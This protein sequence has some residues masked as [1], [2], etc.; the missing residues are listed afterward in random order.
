MLTGLLLVGVTM[1]A[2]EEWE[3]WEE[4]VP[5]NAPLRTRLVGRFP[6]AG[7]CQARARQLSET[8]APESVR[9]LGY[10]CLPA[11]PPQP[12][13]ASPSPGRP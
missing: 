8:A 2:E 1:A 11:M 6:S 9:R 5:A 12:P 4:F 10:T 3:L 13:T 7:A